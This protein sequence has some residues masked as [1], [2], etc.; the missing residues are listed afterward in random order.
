MGQATVARSLTAG[1]HRGVWAR[2]PLVP[3]LLLGL[4][5]LV[6]LLA[7]LL[8]LASP[9]DTALR[10]RFA[11]PFWMDGGTLSHPLGTDSLGRDIL[12]RLIFGARI[13]LLV[14]L[15]AVAL[16]G[17]VG[18]ILGLVAGFYGGWLDVVIMRAADA[19]FSLPTILLA[20]LLA[21]TFGP[22][23]DN[24]VLVLALVLWARF[25]RLVRAETL[26]CKVRDYVA[27]ARVG[28][29][30]SPRLILV[31]IFPN[32]LNPLVVLATLQVG[33][34]VVVEAS[35]SFLGAGVPPPIPTWGTMISEGLEHI[36][37]GW[38]LSVFPGVAVVLL[39]LS[40]NLLGDWLRDYLDPKRRRR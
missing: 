25:A 3:L 35:L 30:S 12:S 21:V 11:P 38:W 33:Y 7:D 18:T 31:H 29:C 1:R 2:L 39:V 6:A 17:V 32:V 24:L 8:A 9:Y 13:S 36:T 40:V 10:L 20:M 15:A 4:F 14:G 5:V 19:M 27:L 16:G 28:G 37:A 34:V 23:L 26:T 22:G